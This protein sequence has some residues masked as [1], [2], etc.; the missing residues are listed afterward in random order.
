M[1]APPRRSVIVTPEEMREL[2]EY[3]ESMSDDEFRQAL[4]EWVEAFTATTGDE[5]T[6]EEATDA[7]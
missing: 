5:P 1:P 6:D 2:A 3:M 7:H 4:R